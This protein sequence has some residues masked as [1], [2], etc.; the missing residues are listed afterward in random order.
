[1][2]ASL[3]V[4]EE[5]Y[6]PDVRAIFFETSTKKDFKDEE[7]KENFFYKYLGF[8]LEH[9]PHLAWVAWDQKVLGYVVAA[10]VSETE[11]L[12]KI[13]PHLKAFAAHFRNYPAHLHI[14]CHPESQGK[15]IGG[16]LVKKVV[17][18]LKSMKVPGLHIMTGVDATNQSFYKK[19]GF[20]YSVKENF[21]GSTILL[22]GKRLSED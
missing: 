10:P 13:Q 1:M 12:E 7:E 20:D 2:S 19:L 17:S 6:L 18:E 15:G 21:H 22:M 3:V 14:N 16:Q 9:F 4:F 11:D 5:K 8:Y